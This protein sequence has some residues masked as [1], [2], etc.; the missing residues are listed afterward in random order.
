MNVP[1]KAQGRRSPADRQ[2]PFRP[3]RTGKRTWSCIAAGLL[4]TLLPDLAPAGDVYYADT[5]WTG[6]GATIETG[7]MLVEDGRIVAVGPRDEVEVPAGTI[8]HELGPVALVPGLVA[9]RTT[10]AEGGRDEERAVT[11]YI[12]ALDGFDPFGEYDR[13]LAAGVTTVQLSPGS[14]RIMPG[15]GAVVKLAGEDS[16]RQTLRELESLRILLTEAAFNPPRIYEPPVGA[17]SEDNPF[18]PTKPQLAANLGD[19]VAGLRAL[20]IARRT[21]AAA[22][23]LVLG[24]LDEVI[25]A[26]RTVRFTV[27]SPSEI[28]AANQLAEQFELPLILVGL[29]EVEA[30]AEAIPWQS[31]LLQGVILETADGLGTLSSLPVPGPEDDPPATPWRRARLLA[32]LGLIEKM[33]VTTGDDQWDDIW[34]AAGQFLAADLDRSEVLRMLTANPAAMLKVSDRVGSLAAGKDADFVVLSGRPFAA[35]TR[36]L[37]TFVEGIRVYDRTAGDDT[38]VIRA[39]AIYTAAGTIE[40]GAITVRGKSIRGVGSSVSFPADA[41][42]HDFGDAVI[43]P[44]FIDGETRVG[45]GGGFGDRVQL[46][47]KLGELLVSDDGQVSVARQGGVTTGLLASSNLPSPVVA[48]KLSDQPRVLRDPV[49]IRYEI[50]GNLTDTKQKLDSTLKSGKA[51]A[52]S[53]TKYEAEYAE[54]KKKL[55]AYERAKAEYEKAKAA[56]EKKAAEEKAKQ[57]KEQDSS[58][59]KGESKDE[60]ESDADQPDEEASGD[61]NGEKKSESGEKAG[62]DDKDAKES[63]GKSEE[64]EKL[65]APKAPEEPKKPKQ[66][67]RLEPYRP[68]FAGEIAAIVEVTNPL[69]LELGVEMFVDRYGLRTIFA[70]G[71]DADRAAAAL[72]GKAKTAVVVTPPLLRTEE[73]E[74][75]HRAERFISAGVPTTIASGAGTGAKQLPTAVAHAVYRGLGQRDALRALTD[76]PA[77][78]LQLEKV[79]N[80]ETGCDADLVVLSSPPFEADSRVLAVMIDGSWVYRS[81]PTGAN[82]RESK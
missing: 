66:N 29:D 15:Q 3:W 73:G 61:G 45:T 58:G 64:E 72:N 67:A 47:D 56:R 10:L 28:L 14:R 22:E 12:R 51:Y 80:I 70:A 59:D 77:E 78:L 46:N 49:A 20:L 55:A 1:T 39:R 7:A 44:G 69:A 13:W 9:A 38:H 68:L 62:E 34:Y 81:E 30:V 5:I 71:G 52:D 76:L 82:A 32:D 63:N 36:V 31:E 18:E 8:E 2:R 43:V 24:A 60:Q 53:W 42:V 25:T 33:A 35:E 27:R 11:P 75:I 65:V 50:S 74:T 19:A 6:E 57:E 23:D 26:G 16:R 21:P 4:I 79:G 54:Y 41:R 17:V 37:Q 40:G 48:F